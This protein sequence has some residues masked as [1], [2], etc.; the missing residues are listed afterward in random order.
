[1]SAQAHNVKLGLFVI[2]ATIAGVLL[3]LIVGSGRWFQ[4][5]TVVE[6]YFNESV[7]GLDIGS[8]VK[9][10]GVSVG[11]VTRIG[12]TYN[13]YEQDKPMAERHRYVLVELTILGRLIGSRAGGEITRPEQV[14]LEIEKGLRIRL[15]PQG[16]TGTNYLEIDYVD[17]KTNPELPISW[18]PANVYIPS[19]QS[20]FTQFFAA[21]GD[22][23]EKLQKLDL[24]ATFQRLNRLLD[25]ANRKVESIDAGK[26]SDST[27]RVLTKLDTKLDQL[28]VDQLNREGT[29]LLAELRQ[30]NQKLGA[31]LDDPGWKKIPGDASAAA[32]QARKLLEDPNLA[33]AIVHLESTLTRLDRMT[34]GTESDLRK[35]LDNVRQITE[36]LR[37]LTEEAK[38]NP[39]RLLRGAPPTPAKGLQP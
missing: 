18:E 36:N 25:N 5:K 12:F 20:T 10:R 34:G 31:I 27:N 15:A 1:M 14:H 19:A 22:I 26:I 4:S 8:K 39:S 2:G 30:T 29:A 38:Q 24:D 33:K 6:T 13:K 9:Y 35:T 3:L 11:D 7:Q 16:I 23:A 32:A 21:A 17:P 37:D 28:H